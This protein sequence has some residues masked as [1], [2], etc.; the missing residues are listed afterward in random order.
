MGK[1]E[2]MPSVELIRRFA[3]ILDF[4][5]SR[6]QVIVR[7]WPRKFKVTDPRV[8]KQN[9][10]FTACVLSYNN[11]TDAE[12]ADWR[13]KANKYNMSGRDLFMSECLKA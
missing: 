5:E 11:L 1:L 10:K 4:Y 7:K 9:K 2:R 8:K 12:R 13:K 3:G 6:G